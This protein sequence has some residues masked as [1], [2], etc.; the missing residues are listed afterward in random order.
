[1]DARNT[2]WNHRRYRI[3]A[4]PHRGWPTTVA[5]IDIFF[6]TMLFIALSSQSTKLSGVTVDLPCISNAQISQ[7]EKYVVSLTYNQTDASRQIFFQDRPVSSSQ[8]AAE[9]SQLKSSAKEPQIIIRADRE[10]PYETVVD[11]INMAQSVG[12]PSFL[13]VVPRPEKAE[14]RFDQ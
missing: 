1:M 12:I 5:L 2:F 3:R 6:L 9:L 8:L 11:V 14:T 10:I 4:V 13:A 7:V